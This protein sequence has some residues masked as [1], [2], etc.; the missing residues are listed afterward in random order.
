MTRDPA[1]GIELNDSNLVN[2]WARA[3][4]K[5]TKNRQSCKNSGISPPIDVIVEVICSEHKGPMI[6]R[7]HLGNRYFINL[8]IAYQT[9]AGLFLA[10]MIYFAAIN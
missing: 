6:S 7:D 3:Q 10:I 1:S 4:G 5:Q 2:C 8:L 9:V